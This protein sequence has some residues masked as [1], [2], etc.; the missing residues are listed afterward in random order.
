LEAA[1][2]VANLEQLAEYLD[3]LMNG[4]GFTME[5]YMMA[6]GLA[7]LRPPRAILCGAVACAV[8]HG[9]AAGIPPAEDA[10]W[11]AYCERVFGLVVHHQ[12]WKW[13]FGPAW[14]GYDN[15]P[16]GAAARIRYLLARGC[17][18]HQFAHPGWRWL[19]EY[20]PYR[21]ASVDRS[22]EAG[23]T[24]SGSTEGESAVPA[25]PGDAQT[26]ASKDL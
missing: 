15:T 7:V 21:A 17:A 6:K 5:R 8:G 1:V 16:Q 25:Q 18:P 24:R 10:N 19:S 2:N 14:A 12:P 23:E 20:A 22:G 3:G 9:P 11:N 13:C 26:P 4:H